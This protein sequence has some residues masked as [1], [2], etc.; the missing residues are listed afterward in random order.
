VEN[1]S[2]TLK[3]AASISGKSEVTLR[4]LVKSGKLSTEPR[5][6]ERAAYRVSLKSLEAAGLVLSS[7]A[8]S[9]AASSGFELAERLATLEAENATLSAENADLRERIGRA[10][11]ALKVWEEV[12]AP[13]LVTLSRLSQTLSLS[14]QATSQAT[15][16]PEEP[17][18][19][20]K[21]HF[22]RRRS[23]SR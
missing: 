4:R 18:R 11:G 1:A 21:R 23:P 9:Q 8:T 10:E 12:A 5:Q 3:E 17:V 13:A 19:G 2:L 22:W 15:S 7:Q 16:H 20:Q 14:D 6:S